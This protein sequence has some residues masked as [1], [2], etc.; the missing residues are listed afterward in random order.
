[1]S[2]CHRCGIHKN[3]GPCDNCGASGTTYSLSDMNFDEV[4]FV[5]RGANQRAHVVLHKSEDTVGTGTVKQWDLLAYARQLQEANPGLNVAQ[6]ISKAL[7]HDPGLYDPDMPPWT[8]PEPIQKSGLSFEL[9]S[10]AERM[11][12]AHPELTF[13]ECVSKA[14][15][16][17][18][19]LYR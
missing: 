14:L 7:E 5:H 18:P 3:P 13:A 12:Q 2:K 6:A 10:A 17:D 1:M 16:R 19:S 11:Q 4:S 8:P 15:D 9:E